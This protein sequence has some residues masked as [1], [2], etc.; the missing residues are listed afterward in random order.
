MERGGPAAA[1]LGVFVLRNSRWTRRLLDM[2]AEEAHNPATSA[3]VCAHVSAS[4]AH[5]QSPADVWHWMLMISV[6]GA[7]SHHHCSSTARSPTAHLLLDHLVLV[8]CK[9]G[10]AHNA[11]GRPESLTF[12]V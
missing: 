4:A 6:R 12:S 9:A 7:K 3:R 10:V 1:D 11:F 2:L 5:G 8:A